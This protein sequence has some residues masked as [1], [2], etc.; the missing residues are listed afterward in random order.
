[1]EEGYYWVTD[2]GKVWYVGLFECNCWFEA[3]WRLADKDPA[4]VGKFLAPP[5]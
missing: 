5:K 3:T 4:T 1:M 2:D